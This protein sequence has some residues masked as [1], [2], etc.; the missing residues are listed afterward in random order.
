MTNNIIAEFDELKTEVKALRKEL[1]RANS[2]WL[3]KGEASDYVHISRP[4]FNKQV[5]LGNFRK[6]D[7]SSIGIA[8]E[9]YDRDELDEDIRRLTR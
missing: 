7:L 3:T 2:R 1:A 6:H 9:R 5:A 8:G 4:L